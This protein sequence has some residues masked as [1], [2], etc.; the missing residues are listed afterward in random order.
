MLFRRNKKETTKER[1]N[2]TMIDANVHFIGKVGRQWVRIPMYL[3]NEWIE[4]EVIFDDAEIIW[5]K[6][7]P[8]QLIW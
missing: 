8:N 6:D 3:L 2:L 7:I 1:K 4:K 5:N